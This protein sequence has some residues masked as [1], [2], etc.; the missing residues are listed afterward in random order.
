VDI[1]GVTLAYTPGVT[2][3][4]TPGVTLAYIPGVTLTHTP[5]ATLGD[6]KQPA[7]EKKSK[8]SWGTPWGWFLG[9]G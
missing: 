3:A 9:Y 4:H 6:T 1:P 2:L 7:P 5:G 8:G